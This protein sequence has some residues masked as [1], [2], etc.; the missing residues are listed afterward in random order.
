MAACDLRLDNLLF[1]NDFI[2]TYG[3][4]VEVVRQ[5]RTEFEN[6]YCTHQEGV[7][8]GHDMAGHCIEASEILVNKLTQ[9]GY[10]CVIIEGWCQYDYYESCSDRS[11]DA[12]T[13]VEI[14]K[15]DGNLYVDVTG[16]QF[17][18][19]LEVENHFGGAYIGE[20]PVHMWVEEPPN[21]LYEE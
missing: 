19:G 8:D 9:R 13:W 12:H 21:L 11:Y 1:N 17:D 6:K 16:D 15:A 20:T 14:L 3:D 18:W 5:T 7:I 10:S 4:I 2:S